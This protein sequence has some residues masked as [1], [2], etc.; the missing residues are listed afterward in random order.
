MEKMGVSSGEEG[1]VKAG[2]RKRAAKGFP[3]L[4]RVFPFLL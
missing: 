1:P 2:A 4:L 3:V